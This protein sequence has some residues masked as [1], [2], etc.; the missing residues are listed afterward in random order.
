M[1]LEVTLRDMRTRVYQRGGWERE[2]ERHTPAR[3][4]GEI[5]RSIMDL[6]DRM[7]RAGLTDLFKTSEDI[8][9][10]A[11]TSTYEVTDGFYQI[12]GISVDTGSG[13]F[14]LERFSEKERPELLDTNIPW[15]GRPLYYEPIGAGSIELLPTPQGVY[16]VTVRYVPATTQLVGDDDVYDGLNGFDEWVVVDVVR[17]L[18]TSDRDWSLVQACDPDLRRLEERITTMAR[19]RDRGSSK[20]VVDVR[21]R[22]RP[23]FRA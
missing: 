19:M 2:T 4:C 1:A 10:V 8:D 17:K 13:R 12:L 9:T 11:D 5:N 21:G 6:R 20:R 16:T 18:A 14:P 23:R 3:V 22:R 15:S 7:L